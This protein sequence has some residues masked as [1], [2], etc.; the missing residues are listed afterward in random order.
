MSSSREV[1]PPK[2]ELLHIP[3]NMSVRVF[4]PS[5]LREVNK[6]QILFLMIDGVIDKHDASSDI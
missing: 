1:L 2:G 3:E 5:G 4:I 6:R